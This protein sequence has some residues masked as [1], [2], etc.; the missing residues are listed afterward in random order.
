MQSLGLCVIF[1]RVQQHT[2]APRL[3]RRSGKRPRRCSSAADQPNEIAP[4]HGQAPTSTLV[5]MVSSFQRASKSAPDVSFGSNPEL[6]SPVQL[7]LLPFQRC[8]SHARAV[9]R[10]CRIFPGLVLN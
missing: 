9:A 4:L 6:A 3:L 8:G 2:N 7:P 10:R 5:L 1:R